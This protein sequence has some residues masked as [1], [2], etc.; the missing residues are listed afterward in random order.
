MKL[1]KL[2]A[3]ACLLGCGGVTAETRVFDAVLMAQ[4]DEQPLVDHVQKW[5][6]QVLQR[7]QAFAQT[8]ADR[9]FV[10]FARFIDDAAIFFDSQP[11]V[12]KAAVTE[13]W[14]GFFESK[15]APFSWRPEQ[16]VVTQDGALAHSSGPVFDAKGQQ[17]A[18][19]NSVW[20]R[21]TDGSWKV[22]LDK[23]CRS[24]AR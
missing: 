3:F 21:Q 12:G 4:Q 5:Q 6:Q 13:A 8:M 7:E 9:D 2:M 23:G 15:T 10:A 18:T 14:R 19:F 17:I 1:I 22:V 20:R 11:I 16:V 24:A